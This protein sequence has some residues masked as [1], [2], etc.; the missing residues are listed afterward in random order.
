LEDVKR[1]VKVFSPAELDF[2]GP[3]DQNPS[4]LMLRRC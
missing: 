4:N 1:K 3:G 2:I